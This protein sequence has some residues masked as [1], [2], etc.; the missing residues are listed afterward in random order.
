MREYDVELT[1]LGNVEEADC[2]IIAVAHNEFRALGISNIQKLYRNELETSSR[3][4]IDVKGIYSIEEL[5]Q[6]GIRY[7]RL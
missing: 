5:D 7:W 1:E 6:S 2:V 4:L 3:V